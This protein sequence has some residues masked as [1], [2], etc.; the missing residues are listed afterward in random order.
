MS[1]K[2]KIILAICAVVLLPLL[3]WTIW[4]NTA[5]QLTEYTV[6]SPELPAA[7]DGFRIAQVSDLHNDDMGKPGGKV[8]AML[9]TAQPDMI[10][11]TGDLID[12]RCTDLEVALAFAREAVKIAPCYYVTGNHESRMEEEYAQ[13]KAGLLE[14][15]VT[16][17]EDTAVTLERSGVSIDI[18]GIRDPAFETDYVRILEVDL[19]EESLQKVV[20]ED[21]FMIVLSHR[22][23]YMDLYVKHRVDL[24]LTGHAH[25]GQV[26]LPLVGGLYVPNQG[27]FPKYD[28]GVFREGNTQMVVSRG[29]GN[30]AFPFRINNRPEVVLITLKQ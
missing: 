24:V 20:R 23:D 6:Q 21:G 1:K 9:R 29:I 27:L 17:L 19:M 2:I 10:A 16:V 26:R 8:L 5:L 12:S 25:G 7:F 11:I 4:G 18:A 14:M 13:L 30:S 3:I 22:P 28:A 15:G